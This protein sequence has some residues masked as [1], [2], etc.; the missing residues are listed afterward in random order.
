MGKPT[1][2]IALIGCLVAA[3][4]ATASPR[5]DHVKFQSSM[6]AGA[7]A[8]ARKDFA[9]A[10]WDYA[11]AL[12]L[13]PQH[14]TAIYRLALADTLL[15][16]TKEAAVLLHR[17]ADM[18]LQL[19]LSFDT[20]FAALK[21]RDAIKAEIARNTTAD[22]D[23]VK[24]FD[25]LSRPFIAEG[26][27]FDTRRSRLLVSSVYQRKIVAIADGRMRDFTAA[28]PAGLS[29]FSITLDFKRD[30]AWVSAASLMQSRGATAA[31]RDHSSLL[32]FDLCSGKLV[33]SIAGPKD[34]ALGDTALGFDGTVYVTD[35]K[36]GVYRLKS[37]GK[38]LEPVATGLSSAQ[39]IA[40]SMDNR[41]ALVADYALGLMRLDLTNGKLAPVI[42]LD[43][44]TTLG[45]D[46][47]AALP[48]GSF[49]ATQNGIAPARIVRFRLSPDWSRVM[50][51][52]VVARNAPQI[53]DPSLLTAVGKDVYA[54]GIS[55]WA[56]FD[57][58]KTEPVRPVHGFK[59]VRL[60]LP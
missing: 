27:A 29:P 11:D 57:E 51:F 41:T 47:L 39:G 24:V 4:A 36:G 50:R 8:L 49:A 59:I 17:I 34:T 42:V 46:G 55:Q 12:K 26:I 37:D 48:D 35:S 19:P 9:A 54:V 33:A 45:M 3:G 30:R 60:S 1:L 25:G 38:M 13:A 14:P 44:V 58:D 16:N 6:K 52:D 53:A 15:G 31:Q 43:T 22:C 23:C 40:I 32:A 56:S 10:R 18:G 21:N 28:L 2:L 7:D 20:S 5:D